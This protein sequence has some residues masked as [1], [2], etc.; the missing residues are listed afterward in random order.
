MKTNI[1]KTGVSTNSIKSGRS[2]LLTYEGKLESTKY[3]W[4]VN[5]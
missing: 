2:Q 3:E 1:L 4:P 5:I